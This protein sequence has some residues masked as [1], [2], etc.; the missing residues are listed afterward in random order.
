MYV[1]WKYILKYIFKNILI[2]FGLHVI[3]YVSRIKKIFYV[4]KIK[5]IFWNIL[6]YF[7]ISDLEIHIRMCGLKYI[8]FGDRFFVS[9]FKVVQVYN[10]GVQV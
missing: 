5:K 2:Y 3:K 7:Y 6:L 8:Y 1:F 4:S 9:S 10:P